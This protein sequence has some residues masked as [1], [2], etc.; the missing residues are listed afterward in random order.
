MEKFTPFARFTQLLKTIDQLPVPLNIYNQHRMQYDYIL[1]QVTLFSSR[2]QLVNVG[3]MTAC[4][5]LG[6]QPTANKRIQE[7][8]KFGLLELTLSVD[9]RVKN[10]S[11][12]ESGVRYMDSC[13][14]LMDDVVSQSKLRVIKDV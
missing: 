6:S 7:L 13:S 4:P 3:E 10:L 2:G 8:V 9:R 14:K 12:T 5:M 1:G 11:L